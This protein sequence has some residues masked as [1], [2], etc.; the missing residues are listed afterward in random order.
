VQNTIK[1]LR[2]WTHARFG[3]NLLSPGD[4]AALPADIIAAKENPVIDEVGVMNQWLQHEPSE[5][6]KKTKTWVLGE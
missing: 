5:L 1:T 4:K 2:H 6:I 3:L